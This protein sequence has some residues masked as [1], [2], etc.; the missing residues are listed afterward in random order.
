MSQL[1]IEKNKEIITSAEKKLQAIEALN[2][3]SSDKTESYTEATTKNPAEI[4][5]ERKL[6]ELHENRF[7]KR[8]AR[9]AFHLVNFGGLHQVFNNVASVVITF[10]MTTTK[11]SDSMKERMADTA[12]GR[13]ISN[14]LSI[15]GKAVNG[16]FK[17]G[18]VELNKTLHALPEKEKAAELAYRAAKSRRSA[19]E[20]LFMCVAGFIALFPVWYLEN[21]REGFL[22]KVDHWLHPKRTPEEKKASEL[23][24]GDEPKE[25]WWNLIRARLVALVVVFGIDQA[26]DNVDSILKYN[27]QSQNKP[28]MYK[29]IDTIFGW[30][31]GNKFYDKLNPK[32]RNLLAKF[33]SGSLKGN[34]IKLSGI[35]DETKRDV[36]TVIN[37]PEHVLKASDEIEQLHKE[38]RHNPANK[39][40]EHTLKSKIEHIETELKA[41][42]GGLE[43]VERAVFAEQSRLFITKEVF[44]TTILSVV[45][46]GCTKWAPAHKLLSMV[47]M[48]KKDKRTHCHDKSFENEVNT[49][50]AVAVISDSLAPFSV[51]EH[52]LHNCEP[53]SK[54][55]KSQSSSAKKIAAKEQPSS[56]VDK[57]SHGAD[58]PLQVGV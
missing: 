19:V 46:Y 4:E 20:T 29:N 9:V 16:I 43:A 6:Q 51:H 48:K 38:I 50:P 39:E 40:L 13:G 14:V 54:K 34:H 7:K 35:Q 57:V 8:G 56:F 31:L 45:I 42:K 10:V 1:D 22:N 53:H 37:A 15:P 55:L 58:Q 24:P 30:G 47:G 5:N 52:A 26:R 17:L 27:H 21:H 23:K 33:F 44:L 3:D 32:T 18:G 28:G 11:F 41:S 49:V 25:T 12:L 36:L 2:Q